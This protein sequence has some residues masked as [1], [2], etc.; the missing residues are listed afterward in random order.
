MISDHPDEDA[1]NF[2]DDV[3]LKGIVGVDTPA[4]TTRGHAPVADWPPATARDAGLNL[5]HGTLAWFQANHADWRQE[6]GNVLQAWVMLK[7]RPR[8]DVQSP[9]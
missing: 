5:S 8:P 7:S 4:E 3:L 1:D 6:I 9:N 2:Q